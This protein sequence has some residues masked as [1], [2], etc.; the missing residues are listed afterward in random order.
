[1]KSTILHILSCLVAV[2]VLVAVGSTPAMAADPQNV[3]FPQ[4]SSSITQITVNKYYSPTGRYT[5]LLEGDSLVRYQAE[6][7]GSGNF[8]I[9]SSG[10]YLQE[11]QEA[12]NNQVSNLSNAINR[13]L[14][15]ETRFDVI[16]N[17][18]V[19]SLSPEEAAQ[20]ANLAGVKKVIP[21]AINQPDTD[22]GPGWIGAE[23]I[24]NDSNTPGGDITTYGEGIVVGILDTGINFDHPSFADP[25]P[26]DSFDYIAPETGYLGVCDP[27]DP[28]YNTDYICNDKLIGA[29]TYTGETTSPEDTNGHGSHTAS[30]VAGNFVTAST[31][32]EDLALSGVAPHAQII[33]YD[34]CDDDGCSSIAAATAVQQAIANS[35]DVI[36]YSISGGTDPYN[37]IVELAFLEAFDNGIFVAA[38]AG[39]QES[40]P[41]TDGYVNH[42]SP[43]VTTVAASSHDRDFANSIG[44]FSGG[45]TP[46]GGSYSGMGLSNAS[47]SLPI[48]YAG[49]YSANAIC[50]IDTWT[51]TTFS[52][53]IVLCDRGSTTLVSKVEAVAA[54]GGGG[55]VIRNISGGATN[56]PSI[57]YAIPG[58]LINAGS[59]AALLTWLSSGSGH[60]ATIAASNTVHF[61]DTGDIKA[62]F[63]FRG[64]GVNNFEVLKP[65]LTAPGLSIMAAY[66]DGTIAADSTAE[67]ELLQGTSM[68]SPHVAGAAALLTA[69]H[70]DWTP[71][72]IKSALMLSAVPADQLKKEDGLTAADPF[73]F[74]AGRVNLNA[75]ARA[76]L[77]MEES[78]ADFTAADPFLGGN[79][80]A[81]NTPSLQNNQCVAT[82]SW[83]RSFTN[84]AG[85]SATY[86]VT[87]NQ[88]WLTSDIT[89]FT[90]ESGQ[91]QSI[92]FTV[93]TAS[94]PPNDWAFAQVEIASTNSFSTSEPISSAL[95]PVAVQPTASNLPETLVLDSFSDSGQTVLTD[96]RAIEITDLAS[97]TYG[98][99]KADLA[100]ITLAMDPTPD[101]PTD[102]LSQVFFTFMD[103]PDDSITRMVFE[104]T[105]T[106]ANDLD[107]Y[108]FRLVG[109][110]F[111]Y[112]AS[113]A[114]ASALEYY[115][116]LEPLPGSY[117]ILIQNWDGSTEGDAITY[118]SA[119]VPNTDAGNLTLSGPS[120]VAAN[121]PFNLTLN[122][123][124]PTQKGDRLY[125]AFDLRTQTDLTGYDLTYLGTTSVDIRR[126]GDSFYLP[127]VGRK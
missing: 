97:R 46:P 102:D 88:G 95:L 28:Q 57:T 25:G 56:M 105:S 116:D 4:D 94:L 62:S 68:S 127:I 54:A 52:G 35:V 112:Y 77:V 1:M 82:C 109:D 123:S 60:T 7:Y 40:E 3:P 72:M 80:S 83:T 106:T 108:I 111:T 43:W 22:T 32:G 5:V 124:E 75:A 84:V 78:T 110:V 125:G 115:S 44:S 6:L 37:D 92:T 86:T 119:L 12:Q 16:L 76:G 120:V 113:S 47:A 74:G 26:S 61:K 29:Y 59:G 65:D 49:N 17:G 126:V 91:S 122:Y 50:N 66:G 96:L 13:D 51:P 93:T 104:I 19:V 99:V 114:T 2:S 8:T 9:N 98:L 38:S 101:S 103:V 100:D 39:N 24:F 73:D 14:P 85:V 118:A 11:L 10:I 36:N 121:T 31:I 45:T 41:T 89:E 53:Q 64:P 117:L 27:G 15:I 23:D 55:I 69:L 70:P 20:I 90:L 71:A 48:V 79:P 63:S 107:L 30:T 21:E 18:V 33:A 58:T 42:L 81:L 34:I 87:P 67:Y